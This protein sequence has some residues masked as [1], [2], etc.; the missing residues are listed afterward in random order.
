MCLSHVKMSHS[1][2]WYE[3][4]ALIKALF[5]SDFTFR[6]HDVSA[7]CR[8]AVANNNRHAFLLQPADGDH[9][10]RMCAQK[11][12]G[13]HSP[14]ACG[15]P[16]SRSTKGQGLSASAPLLQMHAAH[17]LHL[18]GVRAHTF[19]K[20]TL[21]LNDHFPRREPEQV[22]CSSGGISTEHSWPSIV[23]IM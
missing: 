17:S 5:H 15:K 6:L 23:N 22:C 1:V 14:C 18:F 4:C 19:H 21:M 11:C 7:I 2:S 20:H 8:R 3:T 9:R 10:L 16:R 12:Q 13:E